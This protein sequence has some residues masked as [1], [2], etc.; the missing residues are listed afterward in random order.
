MRAGQRLSALGQEKKHLRHYCCCWC[1]RLRAHVDHN[2]ESA[3]RFA[4]L[5]AL[6]CSCGQSRQLRQTLHAC[7]SVQ[8]SPRVAGML[9]LRSSVRGPALP[10]VRL[11]ALKSVPGAIVSARASVRVPGG[12]MGTLLLGDSRAS[13]T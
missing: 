6:P 3:S 10:A 7:D 4:E 1:W 11:P 9:Y 5:S 2:P 12:V 13:A 8:P